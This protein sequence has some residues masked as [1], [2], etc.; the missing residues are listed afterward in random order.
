MSNVWSYDYLDRF[1]DLCISNTKEVIANN[2]FKNPKSGDF[3]VAYC[4]VNGCVFAQAYRIIG[5]S[6]AQPW[7]EHWKFVYSVQV[8]SPITEIPFL[9]K[10]D[11]K[12][13]GKNKKTDETV[14]NYLIK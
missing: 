14:F 10:R 13:G 11:F 2:K 8:L 1:D 4:K 7:D 5:S 3:A 9:T 6:N 12:R